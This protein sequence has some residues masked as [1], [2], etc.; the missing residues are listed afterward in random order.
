MKETFMILDGNNLVYRAFFALP[1]LKNSRGQYT[2]AVY[3][4]TT[5]LL[6]LLKEEDP[7]YLA[8]A[9]DLAAPTFRHQVYADYKAKRERAPD[10][11]REQIPLVKDILRAMEVEILEVEGFEA[12]DV[13]GTCC[14]KSAHQG[15]ESLIVS[16][17]ADVFQL[18]SPHT[19]VVQVKKGVTQTQLLDREGLKDRMGLFP[20]Q[21][22]DYKALK[23][24]TS[25]NIP[26]VPGI[27]DKTAL[28]LLKQFPSLEEILDNAH[29]VA[30]ERVRRN[31][32]TYREQ[33][34]LSKEL[35]TICRQVPLEFSLERLKRKETHS[36]KVRE[37]FE[38]LEFTS[39]LDRLTFEEEAAP[40]REEDSPR[41]KVREA[42]K[43][44]L[45]EKVRAGKPLYLIFLPRQGKG[46]EARGMALFQE[47]EGFYL[48]FGEG[49]FDGAG[50]LLSLLK[51]VLEDGDTP[52]ITTLGKD[53]L[54]G[55]ADRDIHLKG[56][57]FDVS[58]AAY[59]LDPTRKDF[60]LPALSRDFLK[61]SL[62]REEDEDLP[63]GVALH[64]LQELHRELEG[65]LAALGLEDLFY[66]LELPLIQVLASME[67]RGVK[68]DDAILAA[69]GR[70]IKEKEDALRQEIYALAGETFNINSPVQLREILFEKLKLPVLK[71]TKTGPSTDASVLEELAGRQE[72]V[73]K[74]LQLRYQFK[75]RTTYVEGLLNLRDEKTGKIHTTYN[76][77][78]TATGRLSSTEPNLQNIPIRQEEGRLIR[79]AFIPSREGW[80]L[81][82][83]DYSQIELRLLAHLSGDEGLTR[84]FREGEDIHRKTA[85]EVWHVPLP[86]VTPAMRSGAKAINFGIIYGMSDYGLSQALNISR[87]EAGD[88]IRR[89]F[90]RYPRVKDYMNES[91]RKAR[92]EGFV[93]TL[94]KRRR[95]LPDINH[96]NFNL[97]SFSERMAINTPIQGTA[98][99]IIKKAMVKM[100]GALDREGLAARMLLQV[101]DELVFE[102]PEGEL[103]ESALLVREIMEQ[104]IALSV[105]LT[106]DLKHG[107]NWLDMQ[108]LA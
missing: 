71:K 11:L 60:S 62:T 31:L 23:G 79:R 52:K 108:P 80:V 63:P 78:V 84:A 14:E 24:D 36:S 56:L 104:V 2:N 91:I 54:H 9:F 10:E 33:A 40:L 48:D 101:H 86:E 20:E 47:S 69:M 76:Q 100:A 6:R 59:L 61:V 107:P 99:D 105:P 49:I 95:Y 43:A 55:L 8:V 7:A 96:K 30:G 106:V 68:I 27:G 5:M 25:D 28:K 34:I 94:L 42:G 90:E 77:T 21:V 15:V 50:E 4:F 73:A 37:L 64:L 45:K 66:K 46:R 19:R 82:A 81:L 12:D 32:E 39:L 18:I 85:A 75:L 1:L 29:A 65:S 44:E 57:S 13:I 92:E 74:I 53:A 22:V 97:R 89:Y 26:G 88:F 70:G 102:V 83:A 51:P 3:G 16:G 72:V 38:E 41:V 87:E 103:K 98:A 93:T 17:D 58:I 35:A 67:D